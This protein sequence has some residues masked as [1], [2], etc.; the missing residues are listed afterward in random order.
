MKKQQNKEKKKTEKKI[1]T[2]K[3]RGKKLKVN[4]VIKVPRLVSKYNILAC[5]LTNPMFCSFYQ[6]E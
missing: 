2:E 6:K 1:E 3:I 5:I 4:Q